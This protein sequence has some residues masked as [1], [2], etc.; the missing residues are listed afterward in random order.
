MYMQLILMYLTCD[1]S[2]IITHIPTFA[3]T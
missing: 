3:T 2:M 1:D